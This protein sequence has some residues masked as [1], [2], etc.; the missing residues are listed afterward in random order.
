MRRL[1]HVLALLAL[2]GCSL[3][4][5]Y[6]RPALPVTDRW[7]DGPAAKAAADTP[8]TVPVADIGWRDFFADP[9]MQ[10]LIALTLAN[11]RDL[12]V[13]ALN[14]QQ[15]QAQYR[16]DRASLFPTLNASG[17]MEYTRTPA[18]LSTTGS[19]LNS[20]Q[21]SLGLGATSYEI[22]LFGRIRSQAEQ[23]RQQFLSD[24]ETQ[25]STQIS[26]IAQVASEYLTWLAD[27]ESLAVAQNTERAQTDSLRLTSLKARTGSGTALDVAQA[28]VSVRN[29]QTAAAIY[30]RQVGQ[31]LNQLVLLVGAPLPAPLLD[32]MTAQTGLAAQG[33][34]PPLP[35]G[36]PSDLLARRPDI[37]AAEHTLLAANANIGAAR[38]AFFPQITLTASG[39]TEST[40]MRRLFTGSQGFWSFSPSISVPIFDAGKNFASLDIAK[41][42]TRIEVANYEKAIQSAFKDVSDA[43]VAHTTYIDQLAAERALVDADARYFDLASM[44]FR[45]GTDTYLNVLVAQKDLFDAQLSL[46]S[47]RLSAMQNELTFYKALGGGWNERTP[48][49]E[50]KPAAP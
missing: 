36:L 30:A 20:R 42:E 14:V 23:A 13:A 27:R 24:A 11:N 35:A 38:A 3:I 43:L 21:Y 31:D 4:P 40:Q 18:D 48:V 39:G 5:D 6:F 7:P 46:I 26:L 37:R 32:R 22:D 49:A 9:V 16:V 34:F 41:I 8:G 12:R 15:A 17:N 29:A 25:E 1:L 47:L 45:T 19:A 28:E 10:E 33:P 50:V 2:S 44:R